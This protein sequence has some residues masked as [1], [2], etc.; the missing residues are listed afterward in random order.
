MQHILNKGPIMV[1]VF[2]AELVETICFETLT[3]DI[4][5][6]AQAIPKTQVFLG[7][8]V[9]GLPVEVLLHG[10]LCRGTEECPAHHVFDHVGEMIIE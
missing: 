8:L 9:I 5:V 3:G 2:F 4:G 10:T 7:D 6:A 1:E